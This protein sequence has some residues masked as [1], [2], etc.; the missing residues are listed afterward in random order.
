MGLAP[1]PGAAR[2][3]ARRRPFEPFD[4]FEPAGRDHHRRARPGGHRYR[5]LAGPPRD[6]SVMTGVLLRATHV[7][8]RFGAFTAGGDVSMRGQPGEGAGPLGANGAGKTPPVP[9]LLGLI[10]VGPGR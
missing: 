2:V 10:A 1:R 7:T 6:G 8:R 4:P 9:G 3:L 5:A